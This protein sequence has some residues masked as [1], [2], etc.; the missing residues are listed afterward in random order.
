MGEEVVMMN[1]QYLLAKITGIE[2]CFDNIVAHALVN[3]GLVENMYTTDEELHRIIIYGY[4]DAKAR[5]SDAKT[6]LQT[7]I[8]QP[9]SPQKHK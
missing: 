9:T 4:V 5:I 2:S 7:K 8:C 6:E 3:L 1:R